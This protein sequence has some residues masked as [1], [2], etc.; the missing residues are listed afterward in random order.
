MNGLELKKKAT[1]IRKSLLQMIYTGKTGHTGGALSS[2]DILTALYY[3][4]LNVSP[5]TIKDQNRD[6]FFL[7]KGHCVEGLYCILADQ[8]YFPK[9]ELGTFSQYGS[10]LIGHP[11]TKVNG[12]EA[13]TGA[14]GH[15]LSLAVG[16]AL[17]AKK[18]KSDA[19][20]YVLLGDG[21]LA[22]GSVWEGAMAASN[23][24]LDHLTAIIDR[25]H[26]QI[27]GDT[28]D[29]MELGDLKGKWE[30]FGWRV[31]EVDGHNM[32]ALVS[33][34]KEQKVGQPHM[35][36]AHTIKGKGV[37]YMENQVKWHHGVPS[38]EQLDQALKELDQAR[39]EF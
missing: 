7:S 33:V 6:R 24:K 23:Y 19:R 30:A 14:L 3:E 4:V 34:L 1:D 12:I 2:A 27:S 32:E 10:N 5:Q 25:N 15:G 35:I 8:G 20:F 37:S 31:S 36:I 9:E 17:G 18:D 21:E 22:E 28:E 16:T 11:N 29:V 38:E 26:L 13:N 39:E